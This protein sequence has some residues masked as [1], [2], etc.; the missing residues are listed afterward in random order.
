MHNLDLILTITSGLAAALLMGFIAQKIG[1]SPMVG[2]LLAGVAVGPF[3]PG[4]NADQ[5]LAEQ[6][7]EI[8]IILLMFGVGLH[9]HLKE[10]LAVRRVAI[11]GAIGQSIV[12]T[13]L[14]AVLARAFGWDWSAGLVFGLAI[15]VA[16]TVVLLRVLA[17]Y[18][19]LH[20][21]T[22]HIAVGWLV[23]EDLFTVLVLVLLPELF[24]PHQAGTMGILYALGAAVVK[25]AMLAAF[26]LAVGGRVIP[27]ILDRVVE[28]RSREL[29]TLTILVIALGIAVGSTKVFGVSMP[30]G[31]FLAGM[32]VGRSDFSLRA[33][34]E[35]LPMRDAFAVLFFVSVGMGF[36]PH[37]LYESPWLVTATLAVVML[38]KP[39]TAVVIV[40]WLK[41]PLRVALSV[42]VALAQIG[43]FSFILASLGDELKILKPAATSAL[44]AAA[45]V[46]ISLNP[47]LYGMVQRVESWLLKSPQFKGWLPAPGTQIAG[48]SPDS[49]QG[50]PEANSARYR[51]VVVGYGPVGQIVCRLLQENQIDPTVI[52]LNIDTVRRLREQ[53]IA[54]VYGDASHRDILEAAGVRKAAG[55]ILSSAGTHGNEDTIRMAKELNPSIRVLVRAAFVREIPAL[56]SAGAEAVFSGE[57]E[58][59]IAFTEEVLR[60]LGATPEQI[61]RERERVRAHL[62]GRSSSELATSVVDPPAPGSGDALEAA[63]GA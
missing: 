51:A 47:I 12:A 16:S 10:L 27:W 42:A 45:I 28:T 35:A 6:L 54:A 17:D 37:F 24:G 61:D 46:S 56:E 3:T 60:E 21:V 62:G 22:G 30:L 9:F 19:D 41:Y 59:A 26:T 39:L 38:G 44:V 34:S 52:E 57:G 4:F 20:T 32:V 23:V 2:Y 55:F 7:A 36:N 25:V 8:G 5:H 40:L 11:P 1:L 43:E 50:Q 63:D 31:A 49:H 58:V 29:F 13:V 18:R 48:T 53:G 33:A 14:G 15:S